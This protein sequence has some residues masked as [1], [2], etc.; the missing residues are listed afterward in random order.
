MLLPIYEVKPG[1]QLEQAIFSP[2]TGKCLLSA[3]VPLSIK[4]IEKIKEL[5]I[6]ELYISDRYS[7]FI[8]PDDKIAESLVTDFV[9]ILRHICPHRPEAN[10]ND[11]V[12]KVAEQLEIIIN[13]IS[14]ITNIMPFLVEMKLTDNLKLYEHS[15][16]TAVLSGIVAGCMELSIEDI[17]TTVMA[18]LLHNI[19]LCEMPILIGQDELIGQQKELYQEHPTYGYYFAIQKNIPRNIADCI[20]YHHEKW[21]GSGYPKGLKG[22]EIPLSS[23][24]IGLCASYSADITYKKI[25]RYMAIETLYATSGIYYDYNV[26][27]TFIKN[28]PIY[29]LGEMVRLSTGEA[30]IVSNIRKNEGPRP[31]VK[32]YYNRVN[33]PISEDKVI[34]LGKERT[35]FIKETL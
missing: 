5:K 14:K 32:I 10:M 7:V 25:P 6:E 11:N 31:V 4:N 3:G 27:N 20:Q 34:D 2:E 30:G 26:V 17:I 21:D 13:K 15:I 35:I 29:P 1:M 18:A 12:V 19:G 24:I 9:T 8:S 33:R 22:D 28:I 16:Y 23:R